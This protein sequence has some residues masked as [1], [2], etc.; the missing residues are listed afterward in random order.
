MKKEKMGKITLKKAKKLIAKYP[1]VDDY[2]A[3]NID[4][5]INRNNDIDDDS[6][7]LCTYYQKCK[8]IL[9]KNNKTKEE[10]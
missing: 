5:S 4:Y 9:N 2:I 7:S 8:T 3:L 6:I 10:N 1:T